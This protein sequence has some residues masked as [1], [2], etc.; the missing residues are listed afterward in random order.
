M[1]VTFS[2]AICEAAAHDN[3]ELLEWVCQRRPQ[4]FT[5]DF[6]I[7]SR[8]YHDTYIDG[9]LVSDSAG[10]EQY[11]LNG[12]W[13]PVTWAAAYGNL[14]C[15]AFLIEPGRVCP[16]NDLDG[17]PLRLACIYLQVSSVELLLER[18]SDRTHPVLGVDAGLCRSSFIAKTSNGTERATR[19]ISL[20][21]GRAGVLG[22][23]KHAALGQDLYWTVKYQSSSAAIVRALFEHGA[24][25]E[26]PTINLHLDHMMELAGCVHMD[27]ET[28]E[29]LI[30]HGCN[31]E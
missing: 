24:S 26:A 2:S 19:I 22:S 14:R 5:A 31:P 25:L 3:P 16:Y 8:T 11:I 18:F 23:L 28:T 6:L 15:L 21:C 12:L 13:D 20:L 27:V 4:F 17:M 7:T 10:A 29:L 9:D 1:P 30:T